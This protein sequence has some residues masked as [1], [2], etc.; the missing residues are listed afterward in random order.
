MVETRSK[1]LVVSKQR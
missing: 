1:K